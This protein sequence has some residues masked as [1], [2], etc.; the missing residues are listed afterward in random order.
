MDERA[1]PEPLEAVLEAGHFAVTAEV[2]PPLSADPDDLLR[3][4]APLA[5]LADAVNVTDGAAART[6]MAALAAAA[7][8]V[9]AGIEPVMQMTL[10]DRNRLALQ[11]DLLG[12]AALGVR[13]V[14]CLTGDRAAAGDQPDAKEVFDLDSAGFMAM[15]RRM[16]EAGELPSGRALASPPRLFIGAADSPVDPPPGWRPAGLEKKLEAGT[17]FVQTQYCFDAALLRRYAGRLVDLGIAERARL[18]IGVGPLR[19]VKSAL[20]MNEHLFGVDI[21]D[22]VLKRL[23]GA[24]DEEEEGIRICVELIEAMRETPGIAGAHIMGP[25]S[26]AAAAEAIRRLGPR[27]P[28]A[29]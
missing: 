5:G 20:W 4:V 3:R 22:A 29:G 24:A 7:L 1:P 9:R 2:T 11:G 13:N 10:R 23:E 14:L 25:R 18:L 21:P 17:R 27:R 19:S 8:L 28:R 6:H 12:A 15:A 16:A 26:E